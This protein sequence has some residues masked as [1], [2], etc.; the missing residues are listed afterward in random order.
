MFSS[1]VT[2]APLIEP[3]AAWNVRL[4][5]R[6]GGLDLDVL[7]CSSQYSD[8]QED[9]KNTHLDVQKM[10]NF[11]MSHPNILSA[12]AIP[13]FLCLRR[14]TCPNTNPGSAPAYPAP[15]RYYLLPVPVPVTL[16]V[17]PYISVWFPYSSR[18]QLCTNHVNVRMN[19][20]A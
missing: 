9:A 5:R 3:Q 10:E 17:Y 13:L 12:P 14:S 11:Y 20:V 2:P 6:T 15:V 7:Q 18:L 8:G 16:Q 19:R 1:T 4:G